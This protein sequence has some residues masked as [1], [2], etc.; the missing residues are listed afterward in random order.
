MVNIGIVGCGRIAE[1]HVE[2]YRRMPDVRI[3]V[4]DEQR[5]AA[6]RLGERYDVETSPTT[7]DLMSDPAVVAIDVCVPTS[8]HAGVV[9]QALRA[10][11][12]V[13]CEKPLCRTAAEAS[14]IAEAESAAG[15]VV[16]VGY[17]YRFHPAFQFAKQVLT[18]GII[19]T[20]HM[21]IIRMGGRGNTRVW[22]HSADAGGGAIL[23]MMV[24]GLD[25]ATWLL[26][27]VQRATLLARDTLLGRRVIDGHDVEATAED[28]V[29][30]ELDIGGAKV[31]CQSDLVT[32]SYM[33]YV[34]VHGSNGSLFTSILDQLPTI[35]YCREPAGVF[36]LGS[37]IRH[38][39]QVDLFELELGRFVSALLGE[40]PG[41]SSV[42]ESVE[43][44]SLVDRFSTPAR[45]RD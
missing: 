32:P 23:E 16:M 22:K 18:D 13:F 28:F 39:P 10:G 37:N 2:A 4:A 7:T 14:A 36:N 21:A 12:H 19:G 29:V 11:K 41:I 42:A 31:I 5:E 27:P 15:R 35:V 34:E 17:L 8:H 30:A 26:G 25:L 45:Q 3:V 44:M 43:L 38:F 33:N 40:A 1:R 9:T 6:V 20:P 24:H